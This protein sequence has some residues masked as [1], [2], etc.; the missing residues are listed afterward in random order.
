MG[1]KPKFSVMD[2][3]GD[4]TAY[5]IPGLDSGLDY[6]AISFQDTIGMKPYDNR[7]DEVLRAKQ[8]IHATETRGSRKSLTKHISS[9]CLPTVENII[10][11]L[12]TTS[13]PAETQL[14]R[15]H[16]N[17]SLPIVQPKSIKIVNTVRKPEWVEPVVDENSASSKSCI[18]GVP[19]KMKK[20]SKRLWKKPRGTIKGK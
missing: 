4:V 2:A 1:C 17:R 6:M 12:P 18:P 3:I 16:D 13:Q 14:V 9:L 19:V 11:T 5:M 8:I 15:D 20:V 7:K 10:E